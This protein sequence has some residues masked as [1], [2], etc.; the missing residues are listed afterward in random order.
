MTAA[1]ETG[2]L[3][4]AEFAWGEYSIKAHQLRAQIAVVALGSASVS[5]ERR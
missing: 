1:L 3:R 4:D 2:A 5:S